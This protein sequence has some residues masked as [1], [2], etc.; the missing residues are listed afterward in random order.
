MP[1]VHEEET[2]AAVVVPKDDSNYL[3]E[4][5]NGKWETIDF[6]SIEGQLVEIIEAAEF[7]KV[8]MQINSSLANGLIAHLT[9][10]SI[11]FVQPA[12][13]ENY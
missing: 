2:E 5:E 11:P 12:D 7:G 3:I 9:F 1:Q 10:N 4:T 6:V 13:E 8:T